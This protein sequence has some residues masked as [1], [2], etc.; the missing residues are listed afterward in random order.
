MRSI[1]SALATAL[2][3]GTSTSAIAETSSGDFAVYGWGA[4]DCT[5]IVTML[6]GDQAAQAQGQIAEWISG[7]I[8]SQNR[9]RDSVYDLTPI[10]T[11][12]PLVSLARNICAN[13][14]DQLLE[15]VVYALVEGFSALRLPTNGPV[16]S[17]SHKGKTVSVN[18]MTLLS[19]QKFLISV[20]LLEVGSADGKFG[21][22]TAEALEKWQ[23]SANLTPNGLPDMM[24]LFLI[25]QKL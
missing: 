6:E 25:S 16:V 22:K 11:H 5:T 9:V 17:L 21:A 1:C 19:V 24:T 10:K 14:S 12:Y 18:E 15:N 13:N 8:S 3:A 2:V 23:Y 20:D 7:Y 4:R